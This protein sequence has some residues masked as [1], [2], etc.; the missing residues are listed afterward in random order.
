M[1]GYNSGELIGKTISFLNAPTDKTPVETKDGII[2]AF[3]FSK[4]P[5]VISDLDIN[6]SSCYSI[7]F[8]PASIHN[9]TQIPKILIMNKSMKIIIDCGC[10]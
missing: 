9:S 7:F 1:C 4:I 10:G 3:P 5:W 8:H 6:T 2:Q